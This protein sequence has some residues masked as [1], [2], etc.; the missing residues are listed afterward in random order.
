V[1]L[2]DRGPVKEALDDCGITCDA[3]RGGFGSQRGTA[4]LRPS[5]PAVSSA[6][7][8]VLEQSM[9]EAVDRGD[10]RLDVEHLLLAI[11]HEPGGR[12]QKAVVAAGRS[13][14]A[15]ERRLARALRGQASESPSSAP[16]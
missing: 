5:N 12:G 8:E 9:R 15:I 7:R 4:L 1:L 13:P 11:L 2:D 16:A 10:A 14:K 3:V 6:T